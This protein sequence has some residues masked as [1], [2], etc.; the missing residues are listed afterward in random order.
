MTDRR[1]RRATPDDAL[2]VRRLVDGALLEVG[3]V[4]SRIDDGDVLVATES[5]SVGT[6][7]TRRVLG[8]VVFEP[9][10]RGETKGAHV[11]AI[12]VHRRHRGRGIGT[13]LLEEAL[14]RAGA[15]TANFDADVRPFYESLGFEIESIAEGRYR[16][17]KRYVETR[18]DG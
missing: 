3:D 17:V 11:V 16:G 1:V 15:L 12:A 9:P 2:A 8:A 7:E 4:E 13:D 18:T 10:V 5:R 14:E 6:G